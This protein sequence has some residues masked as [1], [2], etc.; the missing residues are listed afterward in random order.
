MGTSKKPSSSIRSFGKSLFP[1]YL[2][3]I[4]LLPLT[5]QA[6]N[7]APAIIPTPQHWQ[8]QNGSTDFS[9]IKTIVLAGGTNQ[10]DHFT[11]K[12]IQQ[13][14]SN[15]FNIKV[16][17]TSKNDVSGGE[18]VIIIGDPSQSKMLS[19][20]I[21]NAKWTSKMDTAGYVLKLNDGTVAIA[22]KSAK[23]R[24]YGAMSL[25]QLLGSTHSSTQRDISISD[26]PSMKIRGL[27]DDM[28]RGQ[29]S[30][31]KNIKKII[32]FLAKYKMNWYQ[33]YMEDIIHFKSF[34]EIGKN[35]GR[36]TQK[37]VEELQ[38]Y[39]QKYH[40]DFVPDLETLAHQG[41]LLYLKPFQKY[42]EYPGSSAFNTQ[43]DSAVNFVKQLVGDILPWFDSDYFHIGGDESFDVGRGA[44][45]TA[46]NTFGLATVQADYYRK[47]NDFVRSHGK[48]VIM[49]GDMVLRHPATLA[50]LPDSLIIMDWHYGATDEYP[51][52]K[53]FSRAGQ[54]FIVSPGVSSWYRLYPNQSAAWVN[55]YNLTKEGYQHG[56]LGS[57]TSTWGDYGG[58]N[59][60]ELNYR[61]YSYLAECAWNPTEANGQTVDQRFDELFYGS[62]DTRLAGIQNLLNQISEKIN[63]YDLWKHPFDRLHS[64]EHNHRGG[65]SFLNNATDIERISQSIVRLDSTLKP[66]LKRNQQQL[67]Y[68]SYEANLAGWAAH[69][70]KYA[71]WMQ[72]IKKNHITLKER[73]SYQQKAIHRGQK[74]ENE[75]SAL[76]SRFD[77]LWLRTNRK[78]NLDLI[79]KLFQYQKI[80]LN[81]IVQSL[82]HHVWDTSYKISSK[83]IA[84]NGASKDHP[85]NKV[86]LRKSFST[87]SGKKIDQA[88]IQEVANSDITLYLNGHKV[89]DNIAKNGSLGLALKRSKYWKV[90]D[91]LHSDSKNVIATSVNSY[92]SSPASANIYLKIKYSDGSTQIIRTD[93]YWKA[94]TSKQPNWTDAG[95]DDSYWLPATDVDAPYTVYKP[96][97]DQ[98]L[99]SYA[100]R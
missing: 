49:Y 26:Y 36:F 15:I 85:I 41:N 43:S 73:K 100:G 28:S 68:F 52:V 74:L 78:A 23:G 17:I 89:G 32:R 99:P 42:A 3:S 81:S 44:S 34:P 71:R 13:A 12:Q 5:S 91:L 38:K 96:N 61:G 6:Q 65:V 39:A 83:F 76:Q 8:W 1:L 86:Y 35:R 84:A 92:G 80:Y 54:P 82:K 87:D 56:A 90:G 40:V 2:I 30:T 94:N 27:S 60:R 62:R 25:N 97:F 88:Y 51:S 53:E 10:Q 72:R 9:Q 58:P 98:G 7:K 47:I 4:F 46:V 20:H 70:L 57:V 59:F 29:V 11:A 75:I 63:Y 48:K 69:S 67:D 18:N 64:F 95:Y 77:K 79:N 66:K 22:G 14:L 16:N 21:S 93:H 45:K 50:Q 31:E 37:E 19:Q 55:T 33:P 24:F